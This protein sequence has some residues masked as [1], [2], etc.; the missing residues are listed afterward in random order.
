MLL[1]A[2]SMPAVF[3]L[4]RRAAAHH[5]PEEARLQGGDIARAHSKTEGSRESSAVT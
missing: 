5:H 3:G 1:E 2:G 4:R